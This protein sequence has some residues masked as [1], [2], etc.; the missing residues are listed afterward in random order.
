M[1]SNSNT[2]PTNAN[3]QAGEWPAAAVEGLAAIAERCS[4]FYARQRASMADILPR[5]E[6]LFEIAAAAGGG[7]G[8]GGGG[9]GRPS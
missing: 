8:G 2:N 7:G 4:R 9:T 1:A 5:L 3:A 6:E